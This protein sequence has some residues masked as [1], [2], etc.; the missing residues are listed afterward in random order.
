MTSIA[1]PASTRDRRLRFVGAL[2]VGALVAYALAVFG[3][4]QNAPE[5]VVA[6]GVRALT[7]LDGV[8]ALV[9]VGALT[10]P[11]T[12]ALFALLAWAARPRHR[13]T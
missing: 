5:R 2:A 4:F 8:A 1:E 10:L 13:G 3:A 9:D 11:L 7:S 6:D 12:V